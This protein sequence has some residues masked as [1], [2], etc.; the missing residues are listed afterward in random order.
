M[1][2]G[3]ARAGI[4]SG[5]VDEA[6]VHTPALPKHAC[7]MEYGK[8]RAG[9]ESGTVDEAR[10]HTPALTKICGHASVQMRR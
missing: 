2:Y 10:V 6:S 1:E 3:K 7:F 8:A 4:E 9:I 5:T